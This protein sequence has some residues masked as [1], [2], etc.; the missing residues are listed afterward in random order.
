M[1]PLQGGPT[2]HTEAAGSLTHR[3]DRL[4]QSGGHGETPGGSDCRC[5]SVS[6]T[7]GLLGCE[8]LLA[9]LEAITCPTRDPADLVSE[10]GVLR[11]SLVLSRVA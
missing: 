8:N 9:L 1:Q 7:G 10:F 11:V 6:I 5:Y 3:S 4:D 2:E